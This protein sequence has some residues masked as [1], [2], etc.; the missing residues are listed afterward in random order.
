MRGNSLIKEIEKSL[1]G[2]GRV[3]IRPSGTEALVR[4]ILEGENQEELDKMAHSL[5]K[6][7]EKKA[8]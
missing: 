1:H 6:L 7:I 4:V 2:C 3:L 5:A 8:N